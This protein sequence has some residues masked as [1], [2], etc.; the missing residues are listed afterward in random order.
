MFIVPYRINSIPFWSTYCIDQGN[1]LEHLVTEKMYNKLIRGCRFQYDDNVQHENHAQTP[2]D[3]HKTA[4]CGSPRLVSLDFMIAKEV[5]SFPPT[6][7]PCFKRHFWFPTFGFFGWQLNFKCNEQ[8]SFDQSYHPNE[9]A[10]ALIDLLHNWE[11]DMAMAS[12]MFHVFCTDGTFNVNFSSELQ[13]V[14]KHTFSTAAAADTT[15]FES[16]EQSTCTC[17]ACC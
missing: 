12:L 15:A 13:K 7:R 10:W 3:H 6:R 2:R 16:R 1:H 4:H 17:I 5:V 8:R 14:L 11:H 9:A